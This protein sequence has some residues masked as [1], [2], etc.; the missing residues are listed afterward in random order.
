MQDKEETTDQSRKRAAV[1]DGISAGSASLFREPSAHVFKRGDQRSLKASS[2]Q[3]T[4]R[5]KPQGN[6]PQQHHHFHTQTNTSSPN[7]L[8]LIMSKL[9]LHKVVSTTNNSKLLL[10]CIVL[11][12]TSITTSF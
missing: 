9:Y 8:K 7:V 4:S 3:I 12:F 11:Y 1:E 5:P 10:I 2:P 6:Q